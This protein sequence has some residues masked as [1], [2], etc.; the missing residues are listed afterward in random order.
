MFQGQATYCMM[1]SDLL[2]GFLFYHLYYY[3]GYSK[4]IKILVIQVF[5]KYFGS[6]LEY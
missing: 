6:S 5:L 2:C 1:N 3:G 4:G